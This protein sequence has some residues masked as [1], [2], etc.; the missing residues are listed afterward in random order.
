MPFALLFYWHSFRLLENFEIKDFWWVI[1][2]TVLNIFTKP[3]FF[4]CVVAVFPLM[5]LIRYRLKKEFFLC[6]IPPFFGFAL[7]ILEYI[8][9]YQLGYY[10]LAKPGE[11]GVT[12]VPFVW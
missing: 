12:I 5:A 1:A 7:I 3:S 10:H 11:S 6:L 9:I 8:A 4:L 2:M